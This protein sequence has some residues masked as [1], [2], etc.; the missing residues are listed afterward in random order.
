[1]KKELWPDWWPLF[2]NDPTGENWVEAHA[3]LPWS[4]PDSNPLQDIFDYGKVSNFTFGG[5]TLKIDH[6][7]RSVVIENAVVESPLVINSTGSG[8]RFLV[9]NCYF[10]EAM[11]IE[12]TNHD[13]DK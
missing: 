9:T 5:G 11:T 8:S 6:D 2:F 7:A 3:G 1:L 12:T 4:D 13:D 10:T